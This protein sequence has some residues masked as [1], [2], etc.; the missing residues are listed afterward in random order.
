MAGEAYGRI[1][2]TFWTDPEIRDLSND[3]QRL[4]L[5]FFTSPHS[6]MIGL[7]RCPPAYAALE[8]RLPQEFVLAALSGALTPYV[9]FDARTDEVFVRK[10]AVHQIGDGLKAGDKRVKAVRSLLEAV[11]SPALRTAFLDYYNSRFQLG[12]EAPSKPLASTIEAPSMGITETVAAPSKPETEAEAD[13][14]AEQSSPSSS[15]A[16]P[17]LS[18]ERFALLLNRMPDTGYGKRSVTELLERLPTA[19]IDGWVNSILAMLDGM[20]VPAGMTPTPEQMA[21]ACSDYVATAPGTMSPAHFRAF[22]VR[23][24]RAAKEPRAD[25]PYAVP[26]PGQAAPTIR[27]VG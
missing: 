6:N 7:Y 8:T 19:Q 17:G 23:I 11:H 18:G 22:V 2:R 3:E 27:R 5:Y 4:L 16:R 25:R 26:K 1:A 12:I 14:D 20:H 21:T 13:S 10:L 9:L 24:C 15:S